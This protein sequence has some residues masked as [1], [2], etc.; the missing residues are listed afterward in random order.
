MRLYLVR[1]GETT[2]NAAG[3]TQGRTDISLSDVGR[4][5]SAL[6]R[7][8][9]KGEKIHAF[10]ASTLVRAQETA[11]IIAAPHGLPVAFDAAIV[12]LN[13]GDLEGRPHADL[14]EFRD[15]RI[16]PYAELQHPNGE[17][18]VDAFTRAKN[19]VAELSLRH[20]NESVV[21]VSHAGFLRVILSSIIGKTLEELYVEVPYVK[22]TSVSIIDVIGNEVSLLALANDDHLV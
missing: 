8:K 1:H 6:A 9:L 14:Q 4:A 20:A 11:A 2:H 3:V 7:E 12:E 17:S 10:Y 16:V 13:Y 18:Y 22:N 15:S 19:F 5:Q 21:V